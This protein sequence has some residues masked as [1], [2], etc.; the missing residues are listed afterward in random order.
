MN[1]QLVFADIDTEARF[2]DNEN[3][4]IDAFK[5]FSSNETKFACACLLMAC[6]S[7]ERKA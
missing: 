5:M 2:C 3:E 1:T 6:E 4:L 7:H